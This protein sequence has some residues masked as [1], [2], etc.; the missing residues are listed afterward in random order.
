VLVWG[1]YNGGGYIASGT[2]YDPATDA[3]AS[4][5]FGGLSGRSIHS[6]VWTGERMLVWGGVPSTST[7][8]A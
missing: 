2:R 8:S 6:A 4:I 1:G 5:P 3:F 7:G